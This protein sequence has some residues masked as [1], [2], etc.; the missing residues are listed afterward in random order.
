MHGRVPADED[1]W[2]YKKRKMEINVNSLLEATLPL[3]RVENEVDRYDALVLAGR[4]SVLLNEAPSLFDEED[5]P[6]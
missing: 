2:R 5:S 6:P 4:V 1:A 3:G